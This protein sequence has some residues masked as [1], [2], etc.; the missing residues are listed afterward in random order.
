LKYNFLILDG[1]NLFWRAWATNVEQLIVDNEVIY[2]GGIAQFIS[3]LNQLIDTFSYKD[4]VKVYLLFDNPTSTIKA[5]QE[6]DENYKSHRLNKKYAKEIYKTIEILIRIL[7]CYSNNFYI[8]NKKDCEADDLTFPLLQ[9]LN[10]SNNGFDSALCIS[11]DLDWS[12]NISENVHWYNFYNV[13]DISLFEKEYGFKPVKNKVKMYKAI[14]GDKSDGIPIG[15]PYVKEDVVLQLIDK[16]NTMDDLVKNVYDS[17]FDTK[18][19]NK[20]TENA[21]RL[22]TNYQLVDFL[23]IEDN[24]TNNIT[25]CDQRVGELKIWYKVLK[26]ELESWMQSTE[27]LKKNF[28]KQKE[29]KRVRGR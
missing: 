14:R 6:I 16:F 18:V 29:Y 5:R 21:K 23:P 3:R 24:I 11:N 26:I 10:I 13:F 7:K 12:R 25:K 19:K 1:N 17:D 20:I 4:M 15:L 8:L 27:E 28:L 2:S 22:I 9:H